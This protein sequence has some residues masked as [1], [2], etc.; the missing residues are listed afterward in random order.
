MQAQQRKRGK[1]H[2]PKES[3]VTQE[4]PKI[5]DYTSQLNQYSERVSF[6]V[7]KK[8]KQKLK[9]DTLKAGFKYMSEYLRALII[10]GSG[11]GTRVIS[12]DLKSKKSLERTSTEEQ[13]FFKASVEFRA[14]LTKLGNGEI[15]LKEVQADFDEPRELSDE[16]IDVKALATARRIG[17]QKSD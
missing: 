17:N 14:T 2:S 10:S 1:L 11:S 9:Q 3:N 16:E 7:S 4:A 15:T 6:K 5:T 8:I 12:D 13:L